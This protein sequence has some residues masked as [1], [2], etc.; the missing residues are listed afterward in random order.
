MNTEKTNKTIINIIYLTY[1]NQ[2][3][4]E[5]DDKIKEF[6]EIVS[7][8]FDIKNLLIID[9]FN[10]DKYEII[11]NNGKVKTIGGDNTSRE[12]SGMLHAFE[13]IDLNQESITT[14][15]LNDTYFS[16]KHQKLHKDIPIIEKSIDFINANKNLKIIVGEINRPT[17]DS[18]FNSKRSKWLSTYLLVISPDALVNFKD[19][20]RKSVDIYERADKLFNLEFIKHIKKQT[21]ENILYAN[22]EKLKHKLKATGTEIT[23][24]HLFKAQNIKIKSIYDFKVTGKYSLILN[25]RRL[26]R[27]VSF[28]TKKPK[29]IFNIVNSETEVQNIQ[30]TTLLVTLNSDIYR[31]VRNDKALIRQLKNETTGI[32]SRL[33]YY[34][35]KKKHKNIKLVQGS[36][37]IFNLSKSIHNEKPKVLII[38]G[39]QE[40]NRKAISNLK[41]LNNI[42]YKGFS[43]DVINEKTIEEYRLFINAW[44]PTYVFICLGA[45]R[46]E[47]LAIRLKN[48]IDQNVITTFIG[49]GGSVD[50]AAGK[51]KRAPAYLSKVGLE[52]LYRFR[53]EPSLKRLLR[54][55]F[56]IIGLIYFLLDYYTG[57]IQIS[58]NK[59]N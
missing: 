59:E 47:Y 57:K 6:C 11:Y 44:K 34:V 19:C 10:E 58:Y 14:L 50:F 24:S 40:S 38:G 23:L 13:Q 56:S 29:I 18:E 39:S 30:K 17:I 9:N 49:A 15:F 31:I 43:P 4:Y 12:F 21:H 46:Q 51:Y 5:S 20:L 41:N 8:R 7:I 26:R 54:L 2:Y 33:I 28:I 25:T 16:E 36:N 37:L 1:T 22:D 52:G 35:L 3:K 53:E 32:D 48:A 45:P 55:Y 27:K 42:E